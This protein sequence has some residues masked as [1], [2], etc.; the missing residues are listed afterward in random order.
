MNNLILQVVGMIIVA[1]LFVV[2]F[3][4]VSWAHGWENEWNQTVAAARKEGKVVVMGPTDA[5]VRNAISG[6]FSKRFGIPL[7]FMIGR[8]SEVA[9]RVSME[10]RASHYT[11]DAVISGMGVMAPVIYPLKVL[12]PLKP[13]LILPGVVD[14]TKWKGGRLWFMDPEER[15]VLRLFM[16]VSPTIFINTR[17]VA[18]E[19]FKSVKALLDPKWRGKI[20]SRDPTSG[21]GG[22]SDAAELYFQFG[23]EF[24]R[25]LYLDQ[26]PV[27]SREQRQ[28]ADW[29]ARGTYPI[30]LGAP[31]EDVQRLQKEG[32]P[33]TA[34]YH[35]PDMPGKIGSGNGTL[36]IMNKAPHPNAARVFVN[37][38]AS[39]EGLEIFARASA[40]PTTRN[41]IDE[42]SFSPAEIIP[43]PGVKYFD[44]SA[45]DFTVTEKER[46]R[47]FM[48]E[49]LK[50]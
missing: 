13:V 27:I 22:S 4:M 25:K 46:V 29:L 31:I 49:L 6:G 5:E 18:P 41:D 14:H 15:Y 9:T 10:R 19:G 2:C 3:F 48:K 23:E 38:I 40:R 44:T 32:F 28:L 24:V 36:G 35:L 12:D 11:L 47:L 8:S 37:W 17:S 34:I 26:Q 1:S 20:S 45:W 43:R 33:V 50:R 30:S 16:S 21:S 7:E 42:L 39:R